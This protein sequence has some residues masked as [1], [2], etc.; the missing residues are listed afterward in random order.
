MTVIASPAEDKQRAMPREAPSENANVGGRMTS[1]P[2]PRLYMSARHASVVTRI[3]HMPYV[4]RG[5]I[6]LLCARLTLL[7]NHRNTSAGLMHRKRALFSFIGSL[8]SKLF[9]TATE[10]QVR[11]LSEAVQAASTHQTV[12]YHNQERLL[13][14]LNKTRQ[15][16]VINH[17]DIISLS[18][19]VATLGRRL[20]AMLRRYIIFD[21]YH[22]VTELLSQL[23]LINI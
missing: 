21:A 18:R 15:Q 20:D 3:P 2:P 22:G 12:L 1:P 4:A 10:S 9:G 5:T 6:P 14:V 13:S 8:S 19:D 23:D 7:A 16:A 17:R 11:G